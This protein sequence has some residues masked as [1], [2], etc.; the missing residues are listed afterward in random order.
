M[1]TYKNARGEGRVF[2]VE[3][4]DQ[5]EMYGLPIC[6]RN[7]RIGG[8][9]GFGDCVGMVNSCWE[10]PNIVLSSAIAVRI[11]I[12]KGQYS[13]LLDTFFFCILDGYFGDYVDLKF[14]G[15]LLHCAEFRGQMLFAGFV[16]T[17]VRGTQLQATMFNEAAR[18]FYD[19]FQLGKVYYISR[20]TLRVRELAEKEPDNGVFKMLR[21]DVTRFLTT[22][23]IGTTY[24]PP[25]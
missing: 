14:T 6:S 13:G 10:L 5:D 23:L 7:I 22:I 3:L 21:C 9:D 18:K 25:P 16:D 17:A 4:T 19:R 15:V 24:Y 12:C 20:G 2:N 1:R 8:A 11:C